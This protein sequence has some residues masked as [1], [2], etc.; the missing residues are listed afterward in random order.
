[1]TVADN[2]QMNNCIYNKLHNAT[3][4]SSVTYR[5]KMREVN[6]ELIPWKEVI[7][8]YSVLLKNGIVVKDGSIDH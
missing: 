3:A 6:D 5:E 1:M 2:Y 8:R 7:L 4:D